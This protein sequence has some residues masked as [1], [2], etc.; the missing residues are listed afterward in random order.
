[1]ST[2]I[3]EY[4]PDT[5]FDDIVEDLPADFIDPRFPAAIREDTISE[6]LDV[7][8]ATDRMLSGVA[9]MRAAAIDQLS[10]WVEAHPVETA[11]PIADSR[12]SAEQAAARSLVAEVSCLLRMP[13]GSADRLLAESRAIAS[14][15]PGT[16]QALER[17]EISY[18]HAQVLIDQASTL[19]VA[20]QADFEAAVLPAARS[21]TVPQFERKAR[22]AR[23]N[24]HP[25]SITVRHQRS[26][27][28]RTA[29][30]SAA[31]DGMASL[32]LYA[33]VDSVT[34][35]F[36]RATDLALSLQGPDEPRTLAQLR[37]DALVDLLIDGVTSAGVGKGI[38]ATV[39]VTVPVMTLMDRTEGPGYLEGYGPI[40]PD[41]A[42]RLAAGAAGFT[43]LLTH[44]E[45]GIVLSV[46]RDRYKTP[47]HL[48]RWLQIRD[49]T[50]R[51]PGCNQPATHTEIDH[52][53]DW[54]FGGLSA[55][56]NL[57]NLC[58]SDHALKSQTGWSLTHD[59]GGTLTWTAPSGRTYSSE[60]A[61][62]IQTDPPGP[63]P[64]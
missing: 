28:D 44:P 2:L 5:T 63:A 29:Y 64:F 12:W 35:A 4:G 19:P 11:K 52:S 41:M 22:R 45:T 31:P 14:R 15:L 46:G 27:A 43:R 47:K 54:Q 3:E 18:R 6:L 13:K 9:A 51:F 23:E 37:A 42:R 30:L 38:R 25:E 59:G 1:M 57:A 48:K 20:A 61:T 17:G 34:A 40:D 60:P 39:N 16:R 26:L 53:L 36:H 10:V 55:H 58:K 50:C 32:T 7:V 56:D 62:T 33:G 49:E 21:L 24:A 8:A